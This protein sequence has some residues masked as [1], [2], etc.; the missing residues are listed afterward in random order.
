MQGHVELCE[1]KHLNAR[2]FEVMTDHLSLV[3]NKVTPDRKITKLPL[4][5]FEDTFNGNFGTFNEGGYLGGSDV[6][7]SC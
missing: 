3:F 4:I 1:N 5:P 2:Q 7:M 6:P